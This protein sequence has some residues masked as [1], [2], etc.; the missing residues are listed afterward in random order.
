MDM[1]IAVDLIGQ[2]RTSSVRTQ[3]TCSAIADKQA[4]YG[5][6]RLGTYS[7]Q[8]RLSTAPAQLWL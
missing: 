1:S 2:R 4:G 6:Y 3:Y 5:C 7:E 8:K